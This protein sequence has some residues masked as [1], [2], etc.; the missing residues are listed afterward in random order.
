[1]DGVWEQVLGERRGHNLT[2]FVN[3][4]LE[5]GEAGCSGVWEQDAG[6]RIGQNVIVFGDRSLEGREFRM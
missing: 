6:D 5:I 4:L 3:R 2:V 1:M